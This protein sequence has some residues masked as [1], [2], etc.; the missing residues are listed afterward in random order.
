MMYTVVTSKE[1]DKM[2]EEYVRV[3]ESPESTEEELARAQEKFDTIVIDDT[4]C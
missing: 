4:E 3:M 1:Y 2:Y